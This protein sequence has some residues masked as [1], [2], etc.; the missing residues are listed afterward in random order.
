MYKVGD[1][2]MYYGNKYTVCDIINS[3]NLEKKIYI[4]LFRKSS[5]YC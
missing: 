3:E 4:I 5:F 2:I 1:V